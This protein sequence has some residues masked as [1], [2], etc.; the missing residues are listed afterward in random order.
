MTK[1]LASRTQLEGVGEK[2]RQA[3]AVYGADA[4]YRPEALK[5]LL[6]VAACTHVAI[7][8][9]REAAESYGRIVQAWDKPGCQALLQGNIETPATEL[10]GGAERP[11]VL[12]DYTSVKAAP[13]RPTGHEG[14]RHAGQRRHQGLRPAEA[15]HH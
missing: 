1:D 6:V 11:S 8:H 14:H 15:N 5:P 10:M 13:L 3:K 4:H 12:Q 9:S 2:R 7:E